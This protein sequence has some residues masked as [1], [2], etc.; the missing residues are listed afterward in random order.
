MSDLIP[1][2]L[3]WLRAGG[4]S[5]AT[6]DARQ[7]LLW[8]AD[9][10]LPYG[11][12]D[13]YADEIAAYEANDDWAP[14]T[15]HTYDSHLRGFFGWGVETGHLPDDPMRHLI[16]PDEGDRLPDPCTD[17]ELARLLELAP[18]KPW[19]LV[20]LLAAYQGLRVSE[21]ARLRRQ[22]ITP[23]RIRVRRGKGRKDAY[24]DTHPIVWAAV[25]DLPM[26]EVVRDPDGST[27]TGYQL[28]NRGWYLFRKLGLPEMRIH[29]LRHW[30]ATSLLAGGADL[31]TVRQCMRHASI[32]STVGYTLIAS[33]VRRAAVHALPIVQ[34]EPACNRLEPTAEAA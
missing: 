10:H 28:T 17:A 29:R 21:L 11:L 7:R 33:N 13:A 25:K 6:I 12:D 30:H 26:G 18:A 9:D 4:R 32:T 31:E 24:I 5:T 8:H 16:R 27:V 1:P 3:T 34:L 15:L 19:R 23:E 22:D 20:W 2:H 14:W